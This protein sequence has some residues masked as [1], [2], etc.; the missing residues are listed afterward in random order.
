MLV[1]LVIIVSAIVI[2]LLALVY[3]KN[4]PHYITR[5]IK[6]NPGR[7]SL[8]LTR[9]DQMIIAHNEN[10]LM[11]LASTVKII[12]ALEYANQVSKNVILKDEPVELN[13]LSKF[14]L[15]NTD[16]GAHKGW[17]TELERKSLIQNNSIAIE[18]VVKG[19]IKFSSNANAEYLIGRLGKENIESCVKNQDL[20]HTPIYPFVSSL[21]ACANSPALTDEELIS[22]SWKIHERLKSGDNDLLHSF[23]TPGLSVQKTW[24]DTLPASTTRDYAVLMNTINTAEPFDKNAFHHVKEILSWPPINKEI[25]SSFGIKGGSTAFV[26]TEALYATDASGNKM[27]MA[28]FFNALKD[29]ERII[30]EW[31]LTRFELKVLLDEKFRNVVIEKLT[32]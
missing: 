32:G 29:W 11:P 21:I 3:L 23:K 1:V 7:T 30:L 28:I 13:E 2:I 9:N 27:A 22:E 25:F 12:I 6:E 17:L 24:S 4:D 15:P 26:L 14:Y 20:S 16:A 8:Y 5:F 10:S 31:N 19:M 18:D